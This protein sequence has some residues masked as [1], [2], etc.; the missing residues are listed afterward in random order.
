MEEKS[1]ENDELLQE[2]K[3]RLSKMDSQEIY[4]ETDVKYLGPAPQEILSKKGEVKQYVVWLSEGGIDWCTVLAR[5]KTGQ[6]FCFGGAPMRP[7][8]KYYEGDDM[9]QAI[10][11]FIKTLH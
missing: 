11:A 9:E 2:A 7:A 8:E 3:E 10:Q 6:Y 1:F 4:F 5:L